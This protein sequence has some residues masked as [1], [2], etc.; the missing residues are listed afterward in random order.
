MNKW[1]CW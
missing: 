1:S